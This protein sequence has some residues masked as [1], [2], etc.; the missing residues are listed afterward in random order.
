MLRRHWAALLM[1][2]AACSASTKSKLD[3]GETSGSNGAGAGSTGPGLGVGGSGSGSTASGEMQ[4]GKSTVGNQI[5]GALLLLLDRSGSMGDPAD[6]KSGQTKYDAMQVAVSQMVKLAKPTLE[7]GLLPFPK[8]DYDSTASAGC[9]INPSAPGC[10]AILADGGCKD[11]ATMPVVAI[12][13]LVQNAPAIVSWL[14]QNGPYGGTPTLYALINAFAIAKAHKTAGQ[15]FVLL[16]TDGVPNTA[17]PPFGPLPAMQTDCKQLSDIEKVV[18]DAAAGTPS[19]HTYVIGSPGS[20]SAAKHLSQLAINGKTKKD[21][22]CSAAAGNCHYQ[23]GTANFEKDL[24][25]VLGSI[26]GSVSDCIF[27]MPMGENIDPNLVNVTITD[28]MGK[29][30]EIFK[31]PAHQDGWDYA[32]AAQDKIQLFG[33]ACAT[34]KAGKG[35]TIT[36]I[37]GCQSKIK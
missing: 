19:V 4:C 23:I 8:G 24:T 6:G 36:I 17:Q 25:A 15:R 34:F 29:Q 26:A 5:P 32:D 27:D 14:N 9:F 20:E 7:V 2:A 28:G 37:L 16:V 22:A 10:A 13:P 12:Q 35:S 1:I 33:P 21:P 31:D 18:A 3:P 11:V 30:T